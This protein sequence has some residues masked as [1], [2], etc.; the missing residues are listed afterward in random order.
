MKLKYFGTDGIRGEAYKFISLDLA[1]KVGKSLKNALGNKD[2]LIGTDTRESSVDIKDA[3]S[4]GIRSTG[5][6]VYFA[7]VVSTPMIALYSKEKDMIGI[8]ITAS[9]NP[10]K[11][12]GIKFFNGGNK[13]TKNE[14]EQIELSLSESFTQTENKGIEK[15][16]NIEELYLSYISDL[17]IKRD[18][19][20]VYDSAN[21]ANYKISN[22]VFSKYFKN[23]TQ[24]ANKPNGKNINDKSGATDLSLI[25]EYI[26]NNDIDIG[27]AFDGDG[28]RLIVLDNLGNVYDGDYINYIIAKHLKQNNKLKSNRVIL[29]IMS[30]PGIIKALDNLNIDYSLVS[31]GD[32]YVFREMIETN[33]IIGGEASGH[34]ILRDY[35][36]TGDGLLVALYL[37]KVLD[38]T[39]KTLSELTEDIK[40]YPFKLKNIENVNKEI[41]NDE[42]YQKFYE[43][44]K[45]QF[46]KEEVFHIRP[47]GT[48][49]LLRVT[50]SM[51]DEEKLNKLMNEVISFIKER[52]ELLK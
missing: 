11:D 13:L 23:S 15:D 18:L 44:I 50:M 29:T 4:E 19:K 26:N 51:K 6:N 2:V 52:D 38:E 34:I 36:D 46:K 42:K 31:V 20:V 8:M 16:I 37:L 17:L 7:G 33:S 28:D 12:N 41:L 24:L 1:N 32:K 9:H 47:S 25:K 27:F 48:E 35:L 45:T 21:G 49:P 5:L 43:S 40:L 22:K 10:Y 39:N 30:N 14:E 3:L